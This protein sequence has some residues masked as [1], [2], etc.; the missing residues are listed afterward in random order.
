MAVKAGSTECNDGF[1]VMKEFFEKVGVDT[2][3]VAFADGRGG[4]PADRFTPEAA[5]DLLRYWLKRPQAKTFRKMLPVLGVNGSLA[6][7]CKHCPAKGKVFAKTGTVGLPDFV[8]GGLV[9]AESLGGYLE[10]KPGR[11]HVFYLVVNDARAQNIDEVLEVFNDLSDIAA[12]RQED[13]SN[14]GGASQG[15]Q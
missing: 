9:L 1:P 11:F 14:Q 8:N 3:Q 5:T 4:N 10:A 13:A 2:D 6:I 12:I 7:D 15:D